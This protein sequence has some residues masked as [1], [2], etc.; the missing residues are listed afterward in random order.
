MNSVTFTEGFN[1]NLFHRE[2]ATFFNTRECKWHFLAYMIRGH[3]KFT[4]GTNVVDVYEG[5]VFFIPKRQRYLSHWDE[6]ALFHSYGF[7]FFPLPDRRKYTLQKLDLPPELVERVRSIPIVKP[8]DSR[9]VGDFYSTL[10]E[11]LPYMAYEHGGK[12]ETLC[13]EAIAYMTQHTNCTVAEV[14]RYCRVSESAIYIAFRNVRHTTPNT[15]RQI[16]LCE[17]AV[18]LLSTTDRPIEEISTALGFSSS[19]YFRKIMREH[20]GMTPREIRKNAPM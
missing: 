10:S 3:G 5:D 1:F 15:Q 11:V 7:H 18:E 6:G 12:E 16:I 4:V 17:R 9:T 14:A 20:T 13:D 19:A 2:K 8:V